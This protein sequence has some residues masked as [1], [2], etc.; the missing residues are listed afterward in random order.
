MSPAARQPEH[1][2]VPS[3]T[4]ELTNADLPR[5]LQDHGGVKKILCDAAV[6]RTTAESTSHKG[7]RSAAKTARAPKTRLVVD[8]GDGRGDWR[9]R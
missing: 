3:A 2:S 1:F 7:E 8:A 5:A 4:R 9:A 6:A